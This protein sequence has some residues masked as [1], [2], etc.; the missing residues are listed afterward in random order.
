MTCLIGER[1]YFLFP[2]NFQWFTWWQK[3]DNHSWVIL[4][5]SWVKRNYIPCQTLPLL[6]SIGTEISKDN[7]SADKTLGCLPCTQQQQKAEGKLCHI[8][9]G[10]ALALWVYS[11]CCFTLTL[12]CKPE[13]DTKDSSGCCLKG[14]LS[15]RPVSQP[16]RP[17]SAPCPLSPHICKSLKPSGLDRTDR[18]GLCQASNSLPGLNLNGLEIVREH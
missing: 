10:N 1:C 8:S 4:V 3:H 14:W 6:K 16:A 18:A 13:A 15:T 5:E 17:S 7:I 2:Q 11:V 9:F 12:F